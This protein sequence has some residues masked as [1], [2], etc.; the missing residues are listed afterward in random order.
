LEREFGRRPPIGPIL[1]TAH[2]FGAFV[3][4]AFAFV[5]A[6]EPVLLE[7]PLFGW[8]VIFEWPFVF[9]RKVVRRRVVLGWPVEFR[10]RGL[11]RR[12]I[13][14]YGPLQLRVV[15]RTPL[16]LVLA[17]RLPSREAAISF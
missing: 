11:T 6:S 2:L 8:R 1:L 15:A 14:I 12:L 4:G 10:R 3:L 13:R 16:E 5:L 7:R 9:E 17:G